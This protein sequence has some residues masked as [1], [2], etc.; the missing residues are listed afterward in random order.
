[1]AAKKK[2][3][4]IRK[5]KVL[6]KVTA[7]HIAL[8]EGGKGDRC[9]IALAINELVYSDVF[10]NVGDNVAELDHDQFVLPREAEDFVHDFD[11]KGKVAPFEFELQGYPAILKALI[12]KEFLPCTSKSK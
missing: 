9:P 7:Q 11:C 10:V 1:M 12:K 6:V 2:P 3:E 4:R 5:V 8:G